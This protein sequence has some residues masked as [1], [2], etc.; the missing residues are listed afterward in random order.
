MPGRSGR[1]CTLTV[2]VFDGSRE[3]LPAGRKILYT[4]RDGN[5]RQ[6]HRK[7]HDASELTLTGLP[8]FN[9]AGD[10]YTVIA[11]SDGYEQAGFFPVT[12][13]PDAPVQA[14]LM[15]LARNGGFNF[16]RAGWDRLRR[17]RPDMARLLRGRSRYEELLERNA[18]VLACYFNLMT[19]MSQ[20]QLPSRTPVSYLKELIWDDMAQ[21]RFFVWADPE[22]ASQVRRAAAQGCFAREAAAG[23]FHPGATDSFKQVQF[24][25]ANV[26][27]TLHE[28]DRRMV[29]GVDCIKV[30]PDIDYFKDPLAHALLE[31]LPNALKRG[32]MTDPRQVYVLRWMAGRRAGIPEFDPPYT[33]V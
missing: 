2:A 5:Q 13:S 27:L 20:I 1:T 29:A 23:K 33:I 8:Y 16:S 22:I 19:A 24:G 7:F 6:V 28:N 21:D 4:V 3:P 10:N 25:E 17:E 14:D 32:R 18:P 30:E 31:V 12:L 26:Q 15:L 9:N 11:S